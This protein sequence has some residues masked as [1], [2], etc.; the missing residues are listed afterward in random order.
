[1]GIDGMLARAVDAAGKVDYGGIDAA[2]LRAEVDA[3]AKTPWRA[4]PPEDRYA[5]LL[6]AYNTLAIWL[7]LK[8]VWQRRSGLAAP[9]AWLRF[10]L[11]STVRV[12]GRRMN[13][14][15]LEFRHIKPFLRRD[16]RG[17]CALVCASCGCPPL[18]GGAYHGA[19]LDAELDLACQAFVRGG[20]SLDRERGILHVS[21]I[22]KWYRGDFKRMGG[23]RQIIA[24]YAGRDDATWIETHQPKV[25]FMKY[26]WTLNSAHQE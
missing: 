6:N 2:E 17:H 25:R 24:R 15:W 19:S 20:Y 21:R 12:G 8:Q 1:M 18:L 11:F 16:P 3:I 13:L 14:F 9:W 23:A 22:L 4:L 7:A 5:F 10:F 26:D